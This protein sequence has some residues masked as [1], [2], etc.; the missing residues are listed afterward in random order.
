MWC[1]MAFHRRRELAYVA[2]FLGGVAYA[3][4][5]Q[6]QR[7]SEPQ[8]YAL[9]YGVAL[10]VAASFEQAGR[11]RF[12]WDRHE[13]FLGFTW[14]GLT[15]LYGSALLQSLGP[16]GTPYLGL[17]VVETVAGLLWGLRSRSRSW[18]VLSSG[19]LGATA[20]SFS[21]SSASSA[22][23]SW[24]ST[25]NVNFGPFFSIATFLPS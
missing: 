7:V 19:F 24:P 17:I 2:V 9:P 15:L 18:V 8:A 22:D 11:A 3:G 20:V 6:W 25:A 13:L 5:L 4:L 16:D 21:S 14:S 1:E 12:V 23:N 10:L